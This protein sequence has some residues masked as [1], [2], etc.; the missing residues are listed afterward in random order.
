[1]NYGWAD[2]S[3]EAKE[4][5]LSKMDEPDRYNIQLYHHVASVIDLR[6]LDVLE[7]SCGRGGGA[8]YIITHLNPRSLVGIDITAE[9]I[10]L[11][12]RNYTIPGLSFIRGDA[13]SLQFE[14]KPFDVIINI[15]SSHNYMSME[16][17]LNEVYRLLK[18]DGYFLFADFRYKEH[19][20]FLRQQLINSGLTLMNE[21]RITPNII[22]A[23]DLDS[24]RKKEFI[25]QKIPRIFRGIAEELMGIKGT[26]TFYSKLMSGDVEYK[27]FV[28]RK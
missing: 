2:I 24:E 25:N 11:C 26:N 17:F 13:E 6:G 18:K 8:S 5:P 12:T 14:D 27:N 10:H 19:I 3:S 4:I 15:E 7:I 1:M 9:A 21:E 28:M 16:K 22:Q 20:N 23:L